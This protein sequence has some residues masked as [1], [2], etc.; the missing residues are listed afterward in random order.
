MYPLIGGIA[1]GLAAATFVQRDDP[2]LGLLLIVC[3]IVWVATAL[4]PPEHG[5]LRKRS[6]F[7][8]E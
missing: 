6:L 1:F 7:R 3:A 2:I 5:R 4:A 8:P